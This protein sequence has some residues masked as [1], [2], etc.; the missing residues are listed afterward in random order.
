MITRW[1]GGRGTRANERFAHSGVSQP[2]ASLNLATSGC[3]RFYSLDSQSSKFVIKQAD[4]PSGLKRP[5]SSF[6]LGFNRGASDLVQR[7]SGFR[8]RVIDVVKIASGSRRKKDKEKKG[9]CSSLRPS[10]C[11]FLV[12]V[13]DFCVFVF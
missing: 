7:T 10:C 1:G 3:R 9:T 2:A 12:L 8:R 5:S 13:Q 11:S 4:N 6:A